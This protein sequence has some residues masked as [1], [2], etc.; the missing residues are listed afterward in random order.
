M[1]QVSFISLI[2]GFASS[3]DSTVITPA[4]MEFGVSEVTESLA[5]GLFLV[6]WGY[7]ENSSCNNSR[8]RSK[9]HILHDRLG[10]LFTTPIGETV[11]R[12]PVYVVTMVLF[13]VFIMAS[14][15]APN[16]GSQLVFRF[17]AGAFGSAPSTCSGGSISDMWTPLER[18]F[19]FPVFAQFSFWGP[20]MGPIVGGFVGQA[21]SEGTISWRW[22]EWITLIFSGLILTLAVLFLPETYGPRLLGWKAA[23]LR[24]ITGDDRFISPRDLQ[25]TKFV[26]RLAHN[27][28]R[29]FIVA[30][31]EPILVLFTLYMS[32]VYIVLYTFLT[33]YGFIFADI[34]DLNNGLTFLC[35]LGLGVGFLVSIPM[36]PWVNR[37]YR[38]RLAAIPEPGG[39]VEP[40]QRLIYLLVG[41][42]FLPIGLFWMAWT[43]Y[44]SLTLWPAVIAT[45]PIGF[46]IM[47]VYVS[48]YQYLI[49]AFDTEA[50]NALVAATVVRYILAGG[51]IE[52]SIPMYRNIG[53]HWTLTL[54]GVVSLILTPVPFVF[55]RYGAAIRMRSRN[56]T[57]P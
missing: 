54:L 1:S 10:A 24:K 20:L 27:I 17:L 41:A 48:S 40:E 43:S 50:A 3:I 39:T 7:V 12:N 44:Q 34:F 57:K 56:A 26:D 11:G 51:M 37:R 42:P 38:K 32:V 53:V 18:T 55:Y 19:A 16:I 15:L 14:A 6:G 8:Y 46:A 4:R 13:M 45:V 35:F 31:T 21:A 2:V 33:G 30:S 52:V 25:E 29:P 22:T 5:T 49:D 23:H 28:Y 47:T 9:S 36:I